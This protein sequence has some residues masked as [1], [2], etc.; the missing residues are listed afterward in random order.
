M[1]VTG[2]T[3]KKLVENVVDSLQRKRLKRRTINLIPLHQPRTIRTN[4]RRNKSLHMNL[5]HLLITLIRKSQTWV[6]SLAKTVNSP[7][8]NELINSPTISASSVEVLD[9]LPENVENPLPLPR[10]PGPHSK[11]KIQQVRRHFS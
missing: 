1:A 11:R 8:S 5:A 2:N 4:H 3:K 7:L 9:T 10:R 6:T